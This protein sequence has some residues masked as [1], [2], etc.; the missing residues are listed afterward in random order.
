MPFNVMELLPMKHLKSGT[1]PEGVNLLWDV[2][3]NNYKFNSQKWRVLNTHHFNLRRFGDIKRCGF[4]KENESVPEVKEMAATASRT[5]VCG[6]NR[7]SLKT[8]T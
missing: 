6:N 3:I 5:L 4:I 7:H 8:F 2:F 1:H